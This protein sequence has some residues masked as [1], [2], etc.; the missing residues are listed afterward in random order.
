MEK[1]VLRSQASRGIL[2]FA[3]TELRCYFEQM[4]GT[5][6][7]APFAIYLGLAS[8]FEGSQVPPVDN[9]ELDDVYDVQLVDGRSQIVGSNPRA[10]LLG[11]YR[12][13]HE[14]G[15]RWVR[16][17]LGGEIVPQMSLVDFT[18]R[19]I[20][21]CE[22]A[23]HRHRGVCIEGATSREHVLD[24][25]AW[26]PKV[27]MNSYF[28]QFRE[29]YAFYERWYRHLGNP[30]LPTEP[31][32]Q[33]M[34]SRLTGEAATFAKCRG[35]LYH[36]VGHG[37]TCEAV[38]IPSLSWVPAE[39]VITPENRELLAEIKGKRDIFNRISMN[40]NLCY[41]NPEAR[42][43]V[44]AEIVRYAETHPE[45][46]YLHFW[47]ADDVNNQCEC[48]RCADTR[49]ADFY[50]MMLNELDSELSAR[51]LRT[52]IV[53]LCYL[54]LLWPPEREQ[55]VNSGRFALM[56]APISRT[57]SQPFPE[58][59]TA[60]V[61]P[62]PVYHRNALVM[63]KDVH[64]N[65]AFLQGWRR[66]FPDLDTFDFDYHLMWAHFQDPGHWQIAEVLHA[67]A[68]RLKSNGLNGFMSCQ[69]QRLFLP[70]G[71]PMA[72]LGRA[73]WNSNLSLDEITNEQLVAEY[74]PD[75]QRARDLLRELTRIFDPARLRGD[76]LRPDDTALALLDAVP[77]LVR[78]YHRVILRNQGLAE[79]VQATSWRHLELHLEIWS[80]LARALAAKL[81]LHSEDAHRFW[82]SALN[83]ARA[84]ELEIARVFDLFE[85]AVTLSQQHFDRIE[86][87]TREPATKEGGDPFHSG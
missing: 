11:V 78:E 7:E 33:A 30:K 50:V 9:H 31:F 77:G 29:A 21:V 36:A 87:P 1:G 79:P 85:F 47:L 52:R 76:S 35:L 65:L 14:L 60:Q 84:A 80:D 41:G 44:V 49:P 64:E 6:P 69:V 22:A 53:M 70:S 59:G 81:H 23:A 67:D 24:L 45:V 57:F 26:L 10:V 72:V 40:T 71:V 17:G 75:W 63:P 34:A 56:F 15:C 46:D 48:L 2:N 28:I 19:Q 8:E 54:D 73:L 58:G 4:I 12:L 83:K 13:L 18:R 68:G 82:R 42:Q 61:S 20:Q 55:I 39:H 5:V 66:L 74:G 51:D 25:I 16:P 62:L 3:E 37:W 27:G 43:K 32:D 38:G 86:D